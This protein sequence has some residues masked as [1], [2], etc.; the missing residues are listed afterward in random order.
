MNNINKEGSSEGKVNLYSFL[1]ISGA[2]VYIMIWAL[3]LIHFTDGVG[4]YFERLYFFV[5]WPILSLLS[6]IVIYL[7][8][9]KVINKSIWRVEG[10]KLEYVV[11]AFV[12]F[13]LVPIILIIN[14]FTLGDYNTAE[15]EIDKVKIFRDRR[16]SGLKINA[17]S[18]I[19]KIKFYIGKGKLG[20]VI[21]ESE[22][23]KVEEL[24]KLSLDNLTLMQE[25]KIVSFAKA[26]TIESRQ[27]ML[28][29]INVNHVTCHY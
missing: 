26:L 27:S 2:V 12:G 18:E 22:L 25:E 28:G 17:H 8:I 24:S 7:V 3:T 9:P 19:A 13:N 11:S 4:I 16:T 23:F 10:E 20:D 29:L 1:Y 15:Y 5:M 6:G 21:D 14:S